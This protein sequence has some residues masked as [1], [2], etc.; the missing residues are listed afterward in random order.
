M[1]QTRDVTI[2]KFITKD[3]IEEKMLEIQAKKEGLISG[4][5]TMDADQRR[6]HRVEDIMNIFGIQ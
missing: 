1:G 6:R 4:A 3:S 2:Y 5:F